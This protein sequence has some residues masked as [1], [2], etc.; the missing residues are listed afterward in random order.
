MLNG[1][2]FYRLHFLD[3]WNNR[4]FPTKVSNLMKP[5]FSF[6]IKTL[7]QRSKD[8]E[9][10]LSLNSSDLISRKRRKTNI[11]TFLILLLLL[12]L[13]H[14]GG[15]WY[16]KTVKHSRYDMLYLSILWLTGYSWMGYS[17]TFETISKKNVQRN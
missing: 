15:S 7:K 4:K 17:H 2:G 6:D 16:W 9:I 3:A 10:F 8:I 1:L 11:K 14:F 13:S 12:L 5:A